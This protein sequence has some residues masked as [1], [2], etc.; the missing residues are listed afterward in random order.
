MEPLATISSNELVKAF[1]KCLQT[2]SKNPL[3]HTLQHV[4]L[5]ITEAQEFTIG[6]SDG[7]RASIWKVLSHTALS[8]EWNAASLCVSTEDVKRF[9]KLIGKTSEAIT[10]EFSDK[11]VRF[12]CLG[13]SVEFPLPKIAYPDLVYSIPKDT[14]RLAVVKRGEIE[15]YLESLDMYE[16]KN[17]YILNLDTEVGRDDVCFKPKNMT[18]HIITGYVSFGDPVV[19]KTSRHLLLGAI[20]TFKHLLEIQLLVKDAVSP[21]V[22]KDATIPNFWYLIMSDIESR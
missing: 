1:T 21:L 9:L 6:S 13:V 11:A 10:I 7:Y 22:L 17:K 3:H 19:A 4:N 16:N 20:K 2:V 12:N 8:H 5:H 14:K 15:Y 18:E